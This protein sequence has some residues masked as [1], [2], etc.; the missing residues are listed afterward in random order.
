MYPLDSD[1][2]MNRNEKDRE[3][4]S[5]SERESY[6]RVRNCRTIWGAQ[7]INNDVWNEIGTM[8]VVWDCDGS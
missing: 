7:I 1:I 4:R 5:E 6:S 2:T 3:P 8:L